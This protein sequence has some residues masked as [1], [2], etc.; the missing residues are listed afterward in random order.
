MGKA[1]KYT[2]ERDMSCRLVR[3]GLVLVVIG[4]AATWALNVAAG[5]DKG[6]S[7]PALAKVKNVVARHFDALPDY[8]PGDLISRGQL[9]PLFG[10][11]ER[12]GWNV[13]DRKEI[14]EATPADTDFLVRQL[15]TQP[16]RKFMRQVAAYPEAYDRLD[17]LSRLPHGKKTIKALIRG[18]DGYKMIRY[19]TTTPGGRELGKQLSNA[20]KA[21]AFNK[22]TA[23]IYTVE[24]LLRRLKQSHAAAKKALAASGGSGR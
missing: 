16:G 22:P 23:R 12:T 5:A 14:L 18:P 17:R 21:A 13:A 7:L 3:F 24:L 8:R 10:R 11:L 2:K 15:R 1:G 4:S 20:P 9:E 19:L 6:K